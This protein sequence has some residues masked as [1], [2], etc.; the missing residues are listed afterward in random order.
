MRIPLLIVLALALFAVLFFLLKPK[1][2][3]IHLETGIPLELAQDRAERVSDLRY[4]LFFSIPEQL[5]DSI[6]ATLS[7]TFTLQNS[8]TDLLLDFKE[9]NDHL[10]SVAVN[11]REIEPAIEQEHIV[12]PDRFLKKG[13]NQVDIQFIAGELSLNRSEE[14]LY[15]LL[16]PDRA[17][18]VFPCFDQPDLKAR[19]TLELEIPG[20]WVAS[21]NGSLEKIQEIGERK[22]YQFKESAPISTYLFAFAA[23]RF[24]VQDAERDGRPMTMFYRESDTAKVAASAKTIFDLHA[25]ALNWL[26]EYTGISYPFEKFDFVLIPT[27]QYGGMEHVGNIFYREGSLMLDEGATTNQLLARASLIAH[28]TAHMWFG[29]LVTMQWFDD[30]W[31]K[32]VFANFMAAKIVN[33]SFPEINHELRFLLAHQPS[34]YG[35][36]RS[37]GAHPIQQPLENLQDA[38][39]L[40]GRIIYQKAPVVMRQLESLVGEA[41][42]R[43]GLREYL[44]TYAFGN[45]S[46]DDLIDIL[47]RK[48]ERDLKQ[49]SQVWVKEAGMPVLRT[50]WEKQDD[51][52]SKFSIVQEKTSPG[53]AYWPQQTTVALIYADSIVK[54]NVAIQDADTEVT[55]L[56]DRPAP[57]AILPN[58]AAISYG[59]FRLDEQSLGYLLKTSGQL[60]DPVLR[61]AAALALYEEF[62]NGT[63]SPANQYV[64]SLLQRLEE[65]NETLNRQRLLTQ[66]TT[67]F[68][69]FLSEEERRERASVLEQLLWRHLR[70][71]ED[72]AAKRAYFNAY[73]SIAL[74]AEAVERLRR[75]YDQELVIEGLPFS[76]S[77][78][79]ALVEALALR[80]PAEADELLDRAIAETQ[81]ADR[82]KR[83]VFIRPALSPDPQVRDAFFEG[84]KKA[85]N[86]HYEPWVIDALN[87]L[88]H[89]LRARSAEKYILPSLE[90]MTE[91]QATG[92]IFFPRRWVGAT[93]S[94]HQSPE[95]AAIVR[96]FLADHPDYPYRLKNKILMGADLLF[97]SAELKN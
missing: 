18:T 17:R 19:F 2:S 62:L 80:L 9:K 3:G 22:K 13:V 37:G 27:F 38:G 95:A 47:D 30:V 35:E 14:Y 20:E 44:Q 97:R 96:Q 46:W 59:Y 32:E 65:E 77:D 41:T 43:D 93:L 10:Q 11:G 6:P 48:S 45:A 15:T 21:G 34:A 25:H 4:D 39:T 86:R 49:W 91:I 60:E 67:V 70:Q 24:Q 52:I 12:L 73:R 23:G 79:H 74:S 81:N 36:D 8:K 71:A 63:A 7:L 61:G 53:G 26:E 5:E 51:K 57:L 58:G 85:E 92:D 69:Q 94:G 90:L 78:R 68:W 83:L 56:I 33:P 82:K 88:H 16:V 54:T 84:L 72:P 42:F 1:K 55:K 75:A 28:E 50:D 76:E 31:L 40:Y 64:E 66:L 87:Y 89:P 29:D